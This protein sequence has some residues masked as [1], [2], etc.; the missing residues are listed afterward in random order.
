M[1]SLT[2]V[3]PFSVE[4]LKNDHQPHQDDEDFRME[5]EDDDDGKEMRARMKRMK[6]E[7]EREAA[8]WEGEIREMN[9]WY[10][11]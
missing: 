8:F 9:R 2:Q 4:L 5:D 7:R 11:M 1:N 3:F 10:Q 6:E